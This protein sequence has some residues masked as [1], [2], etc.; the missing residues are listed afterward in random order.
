MFTRAIVKR[1]GASFVDGITSSGLGEPSLSRALAQHDAYIAA[2]EQCGL[3]VIVLAADE[4]YPD[5]TFIEDTAILT[6]RVAIITN[7]GAE[8]RNGEKRATRSAIQQFYAT[9]AEIETPGTLDGGDVMEVN[10]HFFIGLTTRTN[11][12]G[13]R[14]LISILEKN[15]YTGST[16]SLKSFLH[17]K[18]GVAW[19]GGRNLL[20]AG[21]LIGNPA[22]RDFNII[23]V[24]SEETYAANCIRINDRVLMP[25][26]SIHTQKEITSRGYGFIEVE[27]SEFQKM[28]GGL[29]CLS[30]RF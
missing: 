13:A 9:V 11:A 16:V 19:I 18:T 23:P 5:S 24:S 25:A 12:Q 1:P 14:R 8:S 27:M 26:G 21:E 28:D 15:G 30:L 4:H 7:P 10:G 2:L 3:A 20:A 17:L 6:R 22:F 29:S